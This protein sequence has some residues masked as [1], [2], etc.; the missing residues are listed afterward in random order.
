[1]NSKLYLK[2]FR[3]YLLV[4]LVMLLTLYFKTL[5]IFFAFVIVSTIIKRG[6]AFVIITK[7]DLTLKYI[8]FNL[9]CLILTVFF[10]FITIITIT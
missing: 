2:T 6:K 7:E 8:V 9:S 4:G 1:M 10:V 5:L 3:I